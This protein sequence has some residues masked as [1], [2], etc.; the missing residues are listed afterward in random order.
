VIVGNVFE[1]LMKTNGPIV[2]APAF[3]DTKKFV[4]KIKA[5]KYL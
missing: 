3:G 2:V 1:G 5:G 4:A